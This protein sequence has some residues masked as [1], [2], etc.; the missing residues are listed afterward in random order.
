MWF[1]LFV[2]PFVLGLVVFVYVP[3]GLP[4]LAIV[5]VEHDIPLADNAV[6]RAP[7]SATVPGPGWR[8]RC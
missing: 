2:G 6:D 7:Y 3:I 4:T 5:I 1:W 8:G